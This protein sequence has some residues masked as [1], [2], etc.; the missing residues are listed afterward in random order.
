MTA[1]RCGALGTAVSEAEQ[2]VVMVCNDR[3]RAGAGAL[4]V[5]VM[6]VSAAIDQLDNP[7]QIS[8]PRPLAASQDHA[9]DPLGLGR[10]FGGR[11]RSP[12]V[13]SGHGYWEFTFG[14]G[15]YRKPGG[16]P[17]HGPVD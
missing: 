6:V 16:V 12:V 7:V 17:D 11:G 4:D 13:K 5:C 2:K 14:F 3:G 9:L 15:S 10:Y 1:V 8:E